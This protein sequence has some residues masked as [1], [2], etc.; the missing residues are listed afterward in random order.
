MDGW[1]AQ[2]RCATRETEMVDHEKKMKQQENDQCP[3][4]V[5]T[6]E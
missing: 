3:T 4:T 6:S 5:S 1:R 2:V